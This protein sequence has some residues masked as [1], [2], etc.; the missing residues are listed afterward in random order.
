[1]AMAIAALGFD[2]Q[3]IHAVELDWKT[4]YVDGSYELVPT[5][6]MISKD[7]ETVKKLSQETIS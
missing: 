7:G 5:C 1:M 4:I 2:P 3:T 6:K